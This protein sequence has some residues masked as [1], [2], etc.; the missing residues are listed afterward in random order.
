VADNQEIGSLGVCVNKV[1]ADHFKARQHEH[2]ESDFVMIETIVDWEADRHDCDGKGGKDNRVNP[3]IA[4][5]IAPQSVT[6]RLHELLYP[7]I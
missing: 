1:L 7:D 3:Y 4:G 2:I 5:S 6:H